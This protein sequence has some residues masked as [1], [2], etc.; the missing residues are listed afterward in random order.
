MQ[1]VWYKNFNINNFFFS[2]IN[3][4][5]CEWGRVSF[6][7]AFSPLYFLFYGPLTCL[8]FLTITI[9]TYMTKQLPNIQRGKRSLFPVR[10]VHFLPVN[11]QAFIIIH[12]TISLELH[13]IL[14]HV[15]NKLKVMGSSVTESKREVWFLSPCC[16]ELRRCSLYLQRLSSPLHLNLTP[17]PL[18]PSTLPK[19]ICFVGGLSRSLFSRELRYSPSSPAVLLASI[20]YD[21]LCRQKD[22]RQLIIVCGEWRTTLKV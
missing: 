5:T 1:S 10:S 7:V 4:E 20:L 21:D 22:F 6:F 14:Q 17:E 8:A 13:N 3:N 2:L 9:F 12:I 16:E 11:R 19:K 18:P 15:I